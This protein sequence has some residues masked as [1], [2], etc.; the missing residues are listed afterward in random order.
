MSLDADHRLLT[1]VHWPESTLPIPA[2]AES[3][4][5]YR[6]LDYDRVVHLVRKHALLFALH[7][8][9]AI[10]LGVAFSK[11]TTPLYYAQSSLFL[12]VSKN[13]M[14]SVYSERIASETEEEKDGSMLSQLQLLRSRAIALKVVETLNL[15]NDDAFLSSG[16]SPVASAWQRLRDF[17]GRPEPARDSAVQ[18]PDL[19]REL[20]LQILEDGATTRRV[21]QSYIF[22]I[23]FTSPSPEMAAK[24]SRALTTAYLADRIESATETQRRANDWLNE[25]LA[26]LRSRVSE[27]AN[28][29]QAFRREHGLFETGGATLSDQRL[30]SLQTLLS[31]ARDRTAKA[32][33]VY[34]QGQ[35]LLASRQTADI[36][37]NTFGGRISNQLRQD[38]AALTARIAGLERALGP[39]HDV[40]SN[41]KLDLADLDAQIIGEFGRIVRSLETDYK[42]ALQRQEILES[43]VGEASDARSLDEVALVKLRDLE[44]TADSAK[45][46]YEVYLGRYEQSRQTATF[47]LTNARVINDAVVPRQPIY[48]RLPV[49]VFLAIILGATSAALF[50]AYT[51]T[52]DD[53]FIDEAHAA[54]VTGLQ[55][56]G[57]LPAVGS[58]RSLW[59]R[60]APSAAAMARLIDTNAEAG[61]EE[62]LWAA[63][64]AVDIR[65][66]GNGS[67][68]VIGVCAPAR[69]AGAS[70][71][72]SNLARLF[73]RSADTVLVDGDTRNQTLSRRF[74]FAD[75]DRRVSP[76]RD[77]DQRDGEGALASLPGTR[78]RFLPAAMS[79]GGVRDGSSFDRLSIDHIRA[80]ARYVLVDLP[81][82]SETFDL[83]TIE[84]QLDSIVLVVDRPS[85]S[86][87]GLMASFDRLPAIYGKIAGLILNR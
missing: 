51:E 62:V 24:I 70:T 58:G 50:A 39:S 53:R 25:R 35:A 86:R 20:A 77:A 55:L 59:S 81:P 82:L 22:E 26:E 32:M 17:M 63:K 3:E 10:L 48:P 34:E 87:R 64:L 37:A 29:V 41:L 47:D 79:D 28:A 84:P 45:R 61:F 80:A 73:A 60:E 9:I 74:G 83:R 7:V 42:V 49:V 76:S 75:T 4:L 19:R 18:D 13:T 11:L 5:T 72:A 36:V 33:S 56:L 2:E 40:V 8:G 14:L 85:S 67:S 66:R 71:V 78:L 68:V 16:I 1:N 15:A 12:D 38:R 46:L 27:S 43:Y 23:G 69:G 31:A 54:K 44:R 57:T 30:S 21:A 52:L 6:G 65:A